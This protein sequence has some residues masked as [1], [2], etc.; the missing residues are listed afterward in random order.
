MPDT[1][2][3]IE[4]QTLAVLSSLVGDDLHLTPET[5]LVVDVAIESL[6]LLAAIAA[7]EDHFQLVL[8]EDA[9]HKVVTVR[10]LAEAIQSRQP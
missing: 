4:E 9:L 3:Q 2:E 7:L 6:Q 1:L 8:D 10:D 5:N